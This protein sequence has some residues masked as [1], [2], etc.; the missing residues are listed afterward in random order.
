M[1]FKE[2]GKLINTPKKIVI[3]MHARPD[4]D[5]LGSSLG[6]SGVLKKMGHQVEVIAPTEFPNFLNWLESSEKVLLFSGDTDTHCKKL[7]AE[8]DIIFCLDFSSLKRV[9]NM[10]E[11]LKSSPAKKIVIDHHIDPEDFA[12]IMIIDTEAPAT[13][14]LLYRLLKNLNLIKFI[15]ANIADSLYSGIM[16]DT[17]S[18]QHPNST[19]ESHLI[20]ADLIKLGANVAETSRRIYNTNS[21]N[22]LRFLGFALTNR[23][24]VLN[25][26]HT[27]YFVLKKEDW[28]KY[29]LKIGDTEGLVNYALSLENISIAALIADKGDFIRLSL[30]SSGNIH[31]NEIAKKYFN[32]GG[33]KNAAGGKSNESL[34]DTVKSFEKIIKNLKITN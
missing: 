29:N 21:L 30:R 33:H 34:D 27:A 6:L 5:A 1:N 25:D 11:I 4:A 19:A 22:K 26:Y 9:N 14:V 18:F 20:T 2:I 7:I 23:L 8:A 31:I 3:T 10:E 13:A 12:E 15:D 24:K 16:T 17:G 28:D 32:G